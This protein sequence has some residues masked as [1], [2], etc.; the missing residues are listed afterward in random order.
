MRVAIYAALHSV[1]FG[2]LCECYGNEWY[3]SWSI[4]I[5]NELHR[6]Y[7]FSGKF[8]VQAI[9]V[10]SNPPQ[11]TTMLILPYLTKIPKDRHS[12]FFKASAC[13]K[14]VKSKPCTH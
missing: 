3:G 2:I 1:R 6:K 4:G 13:G 8:N 11:I 12:K 7:D 14:T 5:P 10:G 9:T